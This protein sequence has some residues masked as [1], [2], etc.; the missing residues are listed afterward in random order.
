MIY[1]FI[2]DISRLNTEAALKYQ[3]RT[4]IN[5]I[6]IVEKKIKKIPEG[7]I[8]KSDISEDIISHIISANNADL[9][10]ERCASYMLLSAIM[11]A[12]TFCIDMEDYTSTQ[13][14]N[15]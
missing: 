10:R 11:L 3:N 4:D 2:A 6:C 14:L 1:T 12:L 8:P 15:W 9:R 13:T 5:D 7:K